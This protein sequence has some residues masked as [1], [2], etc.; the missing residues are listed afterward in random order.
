MMFSHPLMTFLHI[1]AV[2]CSFIPLPTLSDKR[3]LRDYPI[4]GDDELLLDTGWE[5]IGI[6]EEGT[7]VT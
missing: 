1:L 3:S 5:A 2:S 6:V 4:R 7:I